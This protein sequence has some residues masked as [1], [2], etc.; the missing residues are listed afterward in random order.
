MRFSGP[1]AEEVVTGLAVMADWT[2]SSEQSDVT[3]EVIDGHG[4]AQLNKFQAGRCC[5]RLCL[6]RRFTRLTNR[7]SGSHIRGLLHS[8]RCSYLH[9]SLRK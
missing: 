8:D 5:I 9:R 7:A 2:V 4:V 6:R 3:C 1:P